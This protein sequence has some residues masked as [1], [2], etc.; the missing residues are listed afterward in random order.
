MEKRLT[1]SDFVFILVFIF[2][3]IFALGAFFYGMKIGK[4]RTEA[5]YTDLLKQYE[6]K[7]QG[8]K[9]YHQSYLVS[10]YHTVYLPFREFNLK[11]EQNIGEIENGGSGSDSSSLIKELSKVA[12]EQYTTME[13]Q[14]MPETSPLLQ[15]G[16][17]NY[18]KSLKLFS[19][20]A[21]SLQS[22]ANG[23]SP[24]ALLA[25]IDKNAYFVEAENFA[26]TAQK[27]YYDAIV[28][29]HQSQ[30]SGVN[31]EAIAKNELNFAE[32]NPL[33]LNLKNAA[34]AS[35]LAANRSFGA[36]TPQDVTLR[37]DEMIK[38]GQAKK[39]DASTVN[40]VVDILLGTHAVRQ[41]DFI[42]GKAKYYPNEV[43]PQLPFFS[44]SE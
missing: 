32:W 24:S 35:I 44:K 6:E 4:D 18:L 15:E 22:K 37:V 40:Q 41:G 11:W 27:N 29:W 3:L 2:M 17:Q 34:A 23:M 31:P 10:F 42:S 43:L 36:F 1:R 7:S 30:D 5:K 26:L 13:T 33:P 20:A 28:Q 21:N 16:H 25:E 39:L 8:L 12:D 14:T 9:A 38:S 19:Q